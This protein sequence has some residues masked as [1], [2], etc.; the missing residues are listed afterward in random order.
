MTSVTCR[1]KCDVGMGVLGGNMLHLVLYTYA[2]CTVECQVGTRY[3][4]EE[5]RL[6]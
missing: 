3:T 5:S 4:S 2:S 1:D 6:R